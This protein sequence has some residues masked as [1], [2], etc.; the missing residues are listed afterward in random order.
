M[1]HILI[2][3]RFDLLVD[4]PADAKAIFTLRPGLAKSSLPGCEKQQ[5]KERRI[6]QSFI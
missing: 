3:G 1:V 4:V 5:E 2:I 6:P